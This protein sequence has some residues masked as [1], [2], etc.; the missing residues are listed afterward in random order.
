MLNEEHVWKEYEG[1]QSVMN[2]KNDIRDIRVGKL[3]YKRENE[4]IY[5]RYKRAYGLI[6]YL[7]NL[8]NFDYSEA[9]KLFFTDPPKPT[10]LENKKNKKETT[11]TR[12]MI[13]I[14]YEMIFCLRKDLKIG[15]V[16][17]HIEEVL[18]MYAQAAI[19]DNPDYEVIS[20]SSNPRH[21]KEV[22]F[23]N[24]YFCAFPKEECFEFCAYAP[25]GY[26][27]ASAQE[28]LEEMIDSMSFSIRLYN[29]ALNN[30][31]VRNFLSGKY[32]L[33]YLKD[34]KKVLVFDGEEYYEKFMNELLR[35]DLS[36]YETL[37]DLHDSVVGSM[38]PIGVLLAT[39]R[40]GDWD[41]IKLKK[42]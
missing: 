39:K 28:I 10:I 1:Y 19:N 12:S 42:F 27:N 4:P 37:H 7:E 32:L 17:G 40:E 29:I 9:R 36:K 2:V 13:W 22:A 11:S 25:T 3:W 15:D 14:L 21:P 20:A 41:F 35:G 16:K 26:T 31:V 34:Y 6:N 8:R 23:F 38:E 30:K 33:V 18:N 24:S 5:R